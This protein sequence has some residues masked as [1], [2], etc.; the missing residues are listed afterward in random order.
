MCL[1]Q[2]HTPGGPVCGALCGALDQ[3]RS[4]CSQDP[5]CRLLVSLSKRSG[6]R[7]RKAGVSA[8]GPLLRLQLLTT[9]ASASGSH[10]L[11]LSLRLHPALGVPRVSTRKDDTKACDVRYLDGV[12]RPLGFLSPGSR[13][14]ERSQEQLTS[15]PGERP[16]AEA[17]PGG[18]APGR[19]VSSAPRLQEH[20]G[21]GGGIAG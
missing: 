18:R 19:E 15:L 10:G 5:P 14:Q 2:V 6:G 20:R 1:E 21:S 4:F 7:D 12:N 17:C 3:D 11:A 9:P 16:W 13:D 8:P